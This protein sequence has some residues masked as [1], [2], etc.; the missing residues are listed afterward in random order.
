M[1]LFEDFKILKT[2]AEVC[3]DGSATGEEIDAPHILSSSVGAYYIFLLGNHSHLGPTHGVRLLNSPE[4]SLPHGLPSP[5]LVSH[6]LSR[7]EGAQAVPSV[8]TKSSL[9]CRPG[10]QTIEYFTWH[11]RF[12][13]QSPPRRD[14][15]H[16]PLCD[17]GSFVGGRQN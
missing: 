8:L 7:E 15:N 13:P 14:A 1:F 12:G 9:L 17:D 2:K 11:S 16:L 10:S 3:R 6:A 5:T 4:S